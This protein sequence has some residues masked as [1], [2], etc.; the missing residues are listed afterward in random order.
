MSENKIKADQLTP[1][2]TAVVR[3]EVSF[4]RITSPYSGQELQQRVADQQQR[5]IKYP[6]KT[7]HTSISLVN[8]EVVFADPQNPTVE[9][10]YI[11]QKMYTAKSGK[12][13]GKTTFTHD[14]KSN[15]LPPVMEHILDEQGNKTGQIQQIQ[16]EGELA[17]G[18]QVIL[19]LNFFA[20]GDN[21][22]RGTGLVYIL[23][24]EPI[25]YYSSPT[26]DAPAMAAMG[27][28]IAGGIT[29]TAH[30]QAPAAPQQDQGY[31]GLPGPG[32]QP[33]V[34]QAPQAPMQQPQQ[35]QYQPQN[36]FQQPQAPQ[37]PAQP[38]QPQVQQNQYQQ[39]H[40]GFGQQY[41]QYGQPQQ[42]QAQPP[43]D[44][45]QGQPVQNFGQQA[46]QAP[47]PQVP[48]PAA[49]GQSPFDVGNQ[50]GQDP[51]PWDIQGNQQGY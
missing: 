24:D 49:V 42:A 35:P 13:Q 38:Q 44:P 17:N 23:S 32:G 47:Q 46:P 40:D 33:Q 28:T 41:A 15:S 43:F 39:P 27:I 5:G 48:A 37:A 51:S 8:A 10:M 34:P 19:V 6:V 18:L 29:P 2:T 16:P 11:H 22:N 7:E 31:A 20:S 50:Q 45:N 26:A 14:D 1:G 25:R 4:S 3:G 9:E 21:E 12:N 36:Q 30:S